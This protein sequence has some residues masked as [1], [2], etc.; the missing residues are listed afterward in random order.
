MTTNWGQF[1]QWLLFDIYFYDLP[2]TV[3]KTYAYADDMVVVH[4]NENWQSL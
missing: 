1:W 4:A 3:S 2:T